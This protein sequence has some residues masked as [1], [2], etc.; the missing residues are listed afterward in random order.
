M[1]FAC[2]LQLILTRTGVT[3]TDSHSSGTWA[4]VKICCTAAE[5][6]GPMPSPGISVTF[7][8]SDAKLRVDDAIVV[9]AFGVCNRAENG[10]ILF[11]D[12]QDKVRPIQR[13]YSSI[14]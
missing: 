13:S 7:F 2:S 3:S 10:T 14:M 6:S 8:T 1:Y 4:A 9:V 5:I 12:Y 11:T